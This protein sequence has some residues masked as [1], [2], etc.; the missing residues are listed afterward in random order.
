MCVSDLA[1]PTQRSPL[2]VAAAAAL[3]TR[4]TR[5]KKHTHTP[6]KKHQKKA[7]AYGQCLSARL[8]DVERNS[9]AS[10]FAALRACFTAQLKQLRPR[11]GG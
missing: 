8:P 7:K 1:R 3:D 2:R 5:T 9:C 11:G 6:N 10:E 4:L